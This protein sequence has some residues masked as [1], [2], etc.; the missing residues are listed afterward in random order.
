MSARRPSAKQRRARTIGAPATIRARAETVAALLALPFLD[1]EQAGFVA[2][3]SAS[4]IRRACSDSGGL[5][6]VRVNGGKLIRIS[7]SDLRAWLRAGNALQ[8]QAS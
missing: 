7:P 5:P 6:H 4:T 1:T 3:T 8:L 2:Q